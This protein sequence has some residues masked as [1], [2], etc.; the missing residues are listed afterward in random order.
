MKWNNYLDVHSRAFMSL[1]DKAELGPM[2]F[3]LDMN[4]IEF[5]KIVPTLSYYY[6]TQFTNED[7]KYNATHLRFKLNIVN[8]TFWSDIAQYV[9][10]TNNNEITD[11]MYVWIDYN[12]K[13]FES[14]M[15]A[16]FIKPTIRYQ[17]GRLGNPDY[18]RMKFEL[19]TEVKFK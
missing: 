11:F 14:E 10:V 2:T 4:F 9:D 6:S 12:H 3:G 1:N 5:F 16:V 19:T 13:L 18:N 7:N 15:G 8:F 17:S